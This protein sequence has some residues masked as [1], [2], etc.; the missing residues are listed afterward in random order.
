M[1]REREELEGE[2]DR[3]KDRWIHGKEIEIARSR[4]TKRFRHRVKT[5]S[6]R[7][8]M[9]V[10]QEINLNNRKIDIFWNI[11]TYLGRIRFEIDFR[12]QKRVSDSVLVSQHSNLRNA[13]LFVFG[14]VLKSEGRGRADMILLGTIT[15]IEF[16]K[17][18]FQKGDFRV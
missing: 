1:D 8:K 10:T 16:R 9:R 13:L 11:Y 12:Q 7:M 3:L 17:I 2:L 15:D 18:Y 14:F 5:E 6:V 4:S